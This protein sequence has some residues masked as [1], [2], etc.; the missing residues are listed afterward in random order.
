VHLHVN[1]DAALEW[2][3]QETIFFDT[4]NVVLEQHVELAAGATFLGCEILCMGGAVRARRS[5]AAAYAS[6]AA[7]AAREV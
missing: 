2:L 4:A 6:A 3:P 7:S 5:I 1:Q